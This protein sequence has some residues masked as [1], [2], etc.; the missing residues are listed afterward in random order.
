MPPSAPTLP[1]TPHRRGLEKLLEHLQAKRAAKEEVAR[2]DT[3]VLEATGTAHLDIRTADPK[4]LAETQMSH[5]PD[6]SV[7]IIQK[8]FN[9]KDAVD[10]LINRFG[11]Q[12]VADSRSPETDAGMSALETDISTEAISEIGST[13]FAIVEEIRS[14][15]RGK[16]GDHILVGNIIVQS[17]SAGEIKIHWSKSISR[18]AGLGSRTTG[19]AHLPTS[20]E[21]AGVT[22]QG[23]DPIESELIPDEE[24]DPTGGFVNSMPD[25]VTVEDDDG[26]RRQ[27]N[28]FS[29]PDRIPARI[30]SESATAQGSRELPSSG[31]VSFL[32]NKVNAFDR[33]SSQTRFAL[34]TAFA[35][36]L[37]AGS[38]VALKIS[39]A[40]DSDEAPATSPASATPPPPQEIFTLEP[41]PMSWAPP[42]APQKM[43]PVDPETDHESMD[44]PNNP[45]IDVLPI[46]TLSPE[47]PPPTKPKRFLRPEYIE[48]RRLERERE[49]A[50]RERQSA[51]DRGQQGVPEKH[52]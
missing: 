14:R 42:P 16:L 35:A 27:I 15:L 33:A 34:Y 41:L 5:M 36:V 38:A 23:D 51:P 52:R 1:P 3:E 21:L 10:G 22:G 11:L 48:A 20:G 40:L 6:A 45:S 43:R 31:V 13:V 8:E 4:A 12:I 28:W 9:H 30:V 39:E 24:V 25:I 32:R 49:K 7:E 18:G 44:L 2:W 47:L 26:T 46:E 19:S 37:L 29:E 17:E 50:K